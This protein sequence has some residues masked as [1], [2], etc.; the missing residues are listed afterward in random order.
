MDLYYTGIAMQH[1][2]YG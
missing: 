1:L 2:L